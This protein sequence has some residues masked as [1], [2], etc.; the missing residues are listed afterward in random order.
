MALSAA[1]LWLLEN[2][3]HK[4]D[5]HAIGF[6]QSRSL[7]FS[8]LLAQQSELS[9]ALA[10]QLVRHIEKVRDGYVLD[11]DGAPQSTLVA[12]TDPELQAVIDRCATAIARADERSGFNELK[13]HY[14]EFLKVSNAYFAQQVVLIERAKAH[15]IGLAVLGLL[16]LC[17]TI[18][19]RLMRAEKAADSAA[20]KTNAL[21]SSMIDAAIVLDKDGTVVA[22]NAQVTHRNF[23]PGLCIGSHFLKFLM[24]LVSQAEL[25]HLKE[26]LLALNESPIGIDPDSRARETEVEINARSAK[27]PT[28]HLGLKLSQ[29]QWFKDASLREATHILVVIS[30]VSEEKETQKTLEATM[31][32]QKTRPQQLVKAFHAV[33]SE[34]R[35]FLARSKMVEYDI[36]NTL[37]SLEDGAAHKGNPLSLIDRLIRTALEDAKAIKLELFEEAWTAMSLINDKAREKGTLDA[38]SC[39]RLQAKLDDIQMLRK[40]VS[41]MIPMM[42][43]AVTYKE[44]HGE[45]AVPMD[46]TAIEQMSHE[47]G[48]AYSSF[49]ETFSSGNT[50][51]PSQSISEQQKA[52][53]SGHQVSAE[54]SDKEYPQASLIEGFTAFANSVA[55]REGKRVEINF[56]GMDT[57]KTDHPHFELLALAGKELIRNSIEHGL[58]IE[59][60]RMLKHKKRIGRIDVEISEVDYKLCLTVRDDG[61]GLDF[62]GI[63][64]SASALGLLDHAKDYSDKHA[65]LAC[66]FKEGFSAHPK[67]EDKIF[68]GKGL[69]R[70]RSAVRAVGGK[71]SVSTDDGRFCQLKIKLPSA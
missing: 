24:P 52:A 68:H 27:K 44:Q 9:P 63:K 2:Q 23:L 7:H 8:E 43:A 3:S 42:T 70:L 61:R 30:D 1:V 18:C 54:K 16:G 15:A 35:R 45:D 31:R 37:D 57:V 21:I 11:V 53:V 4:S 40:L 64:K 47:L 33:P 10:G 39:M 65:L 55:A 50:D 46:L 28:Q 25:Q 13:R 71:V 14:A 22:Q 66:I 56:V 67:E 5:L 38:R 29:C 26:I 32:M 41:A 69:S 59:L 17:L 60:D 49:S 20:Q 12:I 62:V 19:W 48:G 36:R 6:V 34:V 51:Q 58:E